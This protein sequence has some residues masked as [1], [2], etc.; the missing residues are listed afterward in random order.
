[1]CRVI[2]VSVKSR[3]GPSTTT[4]P[5]RITVSRSLISSI[6]RI[7]WDTKSTATPVFWIVRV[8]SRRRSTSLRVRAVVGSSM[9]MSR[10][11][12][13]RARAMATIC[14]AAVG[15]LPT[16]ASRAKSMPSRSSAARAMRRTSPQRTPRRRSFKRPFIAKFSATVRFGNSDRS[17]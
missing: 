17:W 10:A 9:T 1:M 13:C 4:R 5:L 6:S 15:R 3:I 11:S 14:F 2:E 12:A 7:L 8:M 16:S